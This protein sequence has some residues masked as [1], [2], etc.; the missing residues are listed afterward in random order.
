MCRYNTILN[1]GHCFPAAGHS[2]KHKGTGVD[3][4]GIIEFDE[5]HQ[6]HDYGTLD[7]TNNF[8]KKRFIDYDKNDEDDD[9]DDDKYDKYD[10]D[11]D[12]NDDD[13]KT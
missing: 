11:D 12:D 8:F 1:N 4:I 5:H 7:Y 6:R 9:D 10:S 13:V 3:V 2:G